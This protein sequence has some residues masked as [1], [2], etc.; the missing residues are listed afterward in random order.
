[1]AEKKS[2]SSFLY[3]V[4]YFFPLQ[5]LFV[6]IKKNHQ[7]L[8][9]WLILFLVV[10]QTIGNKYGIPYLFLAPEYLGELS[11]A[12]YFIVGLSLGG[13]VM[14]FNISSYIMNAFRFPFLATLSKP[15]YKYSINNSALPA[16]FLVSYIAN[17]VIFLNN[18]EQF[19]TWEITVRMLGFLLGY[20]LFLLL[21][22]LYFLATNKDFEKLFGK[23]LAKVIS[24][25]GKSDEPG[26]ILLNKKSHSWDRT[27][28]KTW[29]IESYIGARFQLKATRSYQHYDKKMLSQVFR[30]NHVNASFFQIAL[31]L[32]IIV[33]GWFREI[34]IV[35][36]PAGATVML[37]FTTLLM[38]T[39]AIRSW[40]KGW[41]MVVM[42]AL[43]LIANQLTK[44][45]QFYYESKAFGMD[46][47]TKSN[48][49]EALKKPSKA[50]IDADFALTIEKLNNWKSK[51]K[52]AKPKAVFI[53]TSG[54]G[55]RASFWSFLALQ[56]LDKISDGK[57]FNQ[58]VMGSG[59]SGGMIGMA[60]YRELYQQKR[61]QEHNQKLAKDNLN[62]VIF[63]LAVN[64]ILIRTQREEI[65]NVMHWKDRGYIFEKVLNENTDQVLNK[66]LGTYT[67]AEQ[68]AEIP[69]LLYTPSIINDS[70]R[71]LVSNTPHR[72]MVNDFPDYVDYQSLFK[73]NDA[74]QLK[75][76]TLLRM[77][78]SFPYIMPSVSLPTQPKIEVFDSGL[79][80]NYGMK[81]I[82]NYIFEI[83]EWLTENTS[84]IVIL[85][86]RDGLSTNRTKTKMPS[87]GV[88]NEV[89]TP[90]GSIYGNWFNVQKYNNEELVNY[91]R[92][93]YNGKIDL[94]PYELNKS[95][96]KNISLS[97]RLTSREKEQIINSLSL[98][99]NENAAQQ[100]VS[101]LNVE[102]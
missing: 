66:T 96:E 24:S 58:T 64:D 90:F 88:I 93:W 7:L 12:S 59:S 76:S 41:S 15:F 75:Y 98:T 48:Y 34:D 42:I 61:H 6:H 28:R 35:N 85:Q 53:A 22:T 31:I 8:L 19:T 82:I 13:F 72:F 69:T 92:G 83:R 91:M 79:R 49:N 63:T 78:A 40:T 39:S 57:L 21:S 55:S 30:Q 87:D 33:L 73:N 3:K 65:N 84:G 37:I 71:L 10:F 47:S 26:Q 56:H 52:T 99:D 36:I 27:N 5:L 11:F 9:F 25:D 60:Y 70:R 14:A 50:N 95:K 2:S 81:T 77:N 32:L 38:I 46:Y 74:N 29:R 62:S 68:S 43:I 17:T 4:V 102:L 89:L 80:D 94:I 100:L 51:Q 67:E 23:E 54:G 16:L 44:Q 45:D 1:M 101:L 97:W 20:F 86:I 18:Y